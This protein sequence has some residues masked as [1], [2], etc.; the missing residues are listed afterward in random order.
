MDLESIIEKILSARIELTREDVV[1]MIEDKKKEFLGFLND[2]G[3]AFIIAQELG[4]D[5]ERESFTVEDVNISD[6]IPGLRSVTV[7]GR[8]VG[9]REPVEFTRSDGSK[10]VVQRI[11]LKGEEGKLLEVILWDDHVEKFKELK[12]SYGDLIRVRSGYTREGLNGRVEL[13]LGKRS[14]LEVLEE[15]K[16]LNWMEFKPISELKLGGPFNVE[17]IVCMLHPP[18]RFK[19]GGREGVVVRARIADRTGWIYLIVWG[20][21]V[22]ELLGRVEVGS[23]VRIYGGFVRRRL[24]GMLELH[25]NRR[26]KIEPLGVKEQLPLKYVNV[27]E[28]NPGSR[29]DMLVRL[30]AFRARKLR[31]GRRRMD[32]LG[33]DGESYVRLIAWE[34]ALSK[35]EGLE[36]RVKMNDLL[37][38]QL[39][40]VRKRNDF[41]E[42]HLDGRSFLMVN[43]KVA[44]A[45]PLYEV[46][47]CRIEDLRENQF[48]GC[49]RGI[50]L[51]KP[52]VKEV[53]TSTGKAKVASM[54]IGDN[55]G[56]VEVSL[57]RDLALTV[58]DVDVGELLELRWVNMRNGKISTNVFSEVKRLGK[59]SSGRFDLA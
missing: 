53:E 24:D 25:L 46:K 4:V 38:I 18:K 54:K 26:G 14:S 41:L 39:G 6:L 17:G 16:T 34:E 27:S 40:R 20:D 31:S 52:L 7:K 42:V 59:P 2:E 10:G 11:T 35:V 58:E 12:A 28:L 19:S 49:I 3:A 9:I 47:P 43:P 36:G 50:A 51:D 30:L 22:K 55:T 13:H 15:A 33:W 56:V 5:L 23:K 45:P 29:V 8:I 48:Y 37:L 32:M 21:I 1:R 44:E 57:W